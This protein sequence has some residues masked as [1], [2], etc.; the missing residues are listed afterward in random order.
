MLSDRNRPVQ[1]SCLDSQLVQH[2]QR[3]AGEVAQLGVVPLALQF[4]DD[5]HR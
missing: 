1:A 4:G 2:S 5:D 3:R